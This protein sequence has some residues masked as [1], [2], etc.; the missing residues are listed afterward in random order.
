[1]AE[2]RKYEYPL[3]LNPRRSK[4]PDPRPFV[5]LDI[6]SRDWQTIDVLGIFDPDRDEYKSF[7]RPD[8]LL[9]Y[10][11]RYKR[12]HDVYA[13]YGGGF[14]FWFLLR[15][16]SERFKRVEIC[17][18]SST[19][20][21]SILIPSLDLRLIDSYAMIP[22]SLKDAC[23]L[24]EVTGYYEVDDF[25]SIGDLEL[26]AR[27]EADCRCLAACVDA[28]R[29]F[30]GE[31]GASPNA[32]TI[33]AAAVDS[34]VRTLQRK[35]PT[36]FEFRD[37]VQES[38]Y[39]GRVQVFC[40]EAQD[41]RWY[42]LNSAYGWAMTTLLPYGGGTKIRSGSLSVQML[43]RRDM[44]GFIGARVRIPDGFGLLPVRVADPNGQFGY[45]VEYPSNCTVDGVWCTVELWE[46][47]E[48]GVEILDVY[49]GCAM[50]HARR[51]TDGR[52]RHGRSA[53]NGDALRKRRSS[54]FMGSLV[55][56]SS[57][58]GF[59]CVPSGRIVSSTT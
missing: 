24:L 12:G 21:T 13:H 4:M 27:N 29:R 20:I 46:A 35:V 47:V 37:I 48:A 7:W 40:R 9:R 6:E 23:D 51:C 25:A 19:A 42:D 10:L 3:F 44:I 39:G 34:W 11:E 54:A 33:A 59:S 22:L 26:R 15:W 53:R 16:I 52:S 58:L 50:K 18:S 36:Q 8:Y 1:M 57:L 28:Y 32:R 41:L 31:L 30:C 43:E 17:R 2:K 14:D 45:R 56:A 55:S 5:T 38:Y 49:G